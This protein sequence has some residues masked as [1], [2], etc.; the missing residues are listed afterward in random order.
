MSLRLQ[1]FLFAICISAFLFLVHRMRKKGA[2]VKYTLPWL[3]LDVLMILMVAFPNA[4]GWICRRIGIQTV[5]NA[6]FFA[7]LLFLLVIV[8]IMSRTISRLNNEI[9]ILAQK[10]ALEEISKTKDK[11]AGA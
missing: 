5:S 4:I 9:R 10:F 6:V 7:A 11:A 1:L 2:D 3:L 8:Y